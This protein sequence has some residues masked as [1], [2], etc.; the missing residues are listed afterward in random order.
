MLWA[1]GSRRRSNAGFP[2][3]H[4]ANAFALALVLSRRWRKLWPAFLALAVTVAW[5]RI[6]LDRHWTSDVVAGAVVGAGLAWLAL[7][8][9]SRWRVARTLR[10]VPTP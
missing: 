7:R 5:S 9:W 8:G 6:Y 10:T 4:A 2:S 3:S 1:D